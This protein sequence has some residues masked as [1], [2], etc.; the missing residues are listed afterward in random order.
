MSGLESDR[1]PESA[2]RN[3]VRKRVFV[4]GL[5]GLS[6]TLTERF[7]R[8]TP[9]FSRL[10]ER[11]VCGT[12]ETVFPPVSPVAWGSVFTGRSPAA[13]G[14]HGWK[15][16]ADGAR[17]TPVRRSDMPVPTIFDAFRDA[18]LRYA[19]VGFPLSDPAP[20]DACAWVRSHFDRATM[21][22]VVPEAAEQL[23]R[24]RGIS[25]SFEVFRTPSDE[26]DY[27]LFRAYRMHGDTQRVAA[28]LCFFEEF[29]LDVAMVHCAFTDNVIH[30]GRS[31]DDAQ[32]AYEHADRL[33][34]TV[35][36][37]LPPDTSLLVVSDHGVETKDV[38]VSAG[39]FLHAAGLLSVA[40]NLSDDQVTD[41]RYRAAMS[42]G[43]LAGNELVEAI[44]RFAD[45]GPGERRDV[46]WREVALRGT[47]ENI[48]F[49]RTHVIPIGPY[50]QL[51]PVPDCEDG[52]VSPARIAHIRSTILEFA[53]L[54]QHPS[55]AG[56]LLAGVE[57]VP[58][59]R[60]ALAPGEWAPS[61][62]MVFDSDVRLVVRTFPFSLATPITAERE[63][64]FRGEHHPDGFFAVVDA[65]SE[66]VES[67]NGG[68]ATI[69]SA[70]P[71]ILALAGIAP[72]PGMTEAPLPGTTGTLQWQS[73]EA[74]PVAVGATNSAT[75][76]S[77]AEH[78]EMIERLRAMG[79]H[80]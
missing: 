77:S 10:R 7:C 73:L 35:L 67:R 58:I 49:E 63:H 24:S 3:G 14:L 62:R 23:L 66:H 38:N 29:D 50:G 18:G 5:D 9:G 43:G 46:L 26:D 31:D 76:V 12:L 22:A 25:P 27:P 69:M 55:G 28:A 1:L 15:R 54:L 36:D 79:Y 19:S 80:D 57:E 21:E 34:E 60:S 6:P 30:S 71:T 13:M 74:K 45:L 72:L 68:R 61:L 8:D 33:V 11:G 2:D 37:Q 78:A 59:D 4:L 17:M 56:T 48:D 65:S 47:L 70:G 42:R 75:E 53:D 16:M 39:A 52:S 40:N 32:A 41:R 64:P 51:V 44:E 20:A